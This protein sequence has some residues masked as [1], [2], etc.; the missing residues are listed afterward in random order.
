MS[1]AFDGVKQDALAVKQFISATS[2]V[3]THDAFLTITFEVPRDE[4]L[5]LLNA[6][7]TPEEHSLPDQETTHALA[8]AIASNRI[9]SPWRDGGVRL[10]AF[11]KW[12]AGL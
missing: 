9:A 1:V 7:K 5:S 4:W 6:V 11:G 8:M 2:I 10:R 12:L 3:S